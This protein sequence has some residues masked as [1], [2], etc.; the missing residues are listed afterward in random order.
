MNKRNE[1]IA[2]RLQRE[3][4]QKEAAKGIGISRSFLTEIENGTRNPSLKTIQKFVDFYGK[5]VKDI[6]LIPKLRN[7]TAL[8]NNQ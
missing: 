4:T 5:E 7:A 1:L 6:F 8:T 3:L 2:L